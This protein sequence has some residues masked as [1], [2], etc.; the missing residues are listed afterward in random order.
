MTNI[1]LSLFAAPTDPPDDGETRYKIEV[2]GTAIYADFKPCYFEGAMHISFRSIQEG[3]PN[4]L[5]HTGYLSHFIFGTIEDI[6]RGKY[7][8]S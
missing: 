1:Q 8:A 4:P 6:P 3:L 2:A 7:L 5:S